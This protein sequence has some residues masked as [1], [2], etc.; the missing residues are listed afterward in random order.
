M[1][2]DL[3]ALDLTGLASTDV[4]DAVAVARTKDGSLTLF[5]DRSE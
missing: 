1:R 2:A 4:D 5:V 3:T